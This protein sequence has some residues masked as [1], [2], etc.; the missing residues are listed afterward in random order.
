M[1][2]NGA[3]KGRNRVDNGA[4]WQKAGAELSRPIK[5]SSDLS[6]GKGTNILIPGGDFQDF[7]SLQDAAHS[8]VAVVHQQEGLARIVPYAMLGKTSSAIV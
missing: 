6:P 8:P 2:R 4:R 3:G 7:L 1:G 5:T